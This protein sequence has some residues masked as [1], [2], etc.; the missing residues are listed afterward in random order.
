VRFRRLFFLAIAVIVVTVAAVAVV[1]RGGGGNGGTTGQG[2]G[3]LSDARVAPRTGLARGAGAARFL[4]SVSIR[5]DGCIDA[6]SFTFASGTP[7]YRIGYETRQRAQT[8]DASGLHVPVT[9]N[10]F[11]VVHFSASRTARLRGGKLVRTYTGPDHVPSA[12]A[13]HVREVVKTGDFEAVVTW[14]I[15][16]DAKHPFVVEVAGSTLVVDVA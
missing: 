15:G 6:V 8:Q 7:A 13:E 4:T 10:A 1:H 12:A 14:A 9:G 3:C 2:H 5:R 16:V 11:L